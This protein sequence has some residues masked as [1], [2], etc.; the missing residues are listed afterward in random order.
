MLTGEIVVSNDLECARSSM[1]MN[2]RA[3]SFSTERITTSDMA[4]FAVDDEAPRANVIAI[5]S[6]KNGVLL[7]PHLLGAHIDWPFGAKQITH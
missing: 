6:H 4:S 1:Q 2:P 5:C 7:R 3:N